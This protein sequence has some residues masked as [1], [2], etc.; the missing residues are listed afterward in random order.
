MGVDRLDFRGRAVGRGLVH[1]GAVPPVDPAR[2][3][4]LHCFGGFP[5]LLGVDELSLVEVVHQGVGKVGSG[6]WLG[7]ELDGVF[8]LS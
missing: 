4:R 3:G 1:A 8:W 2:R 6:G 5:E 7:D